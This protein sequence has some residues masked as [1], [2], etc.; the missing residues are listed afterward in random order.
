MW[1]NGFEGWYYKHQKGGKM[2]AFIPGRAK[3]DAFVQMLT[4]A[5]SRMF[6]VENFA[7]RGDTVEAGGCTF[8]P[9][10]CSVALPGVYGELSYGPIT[11]L[12]SDIM[13]PFRFLPM[14]CRHGVVSMAHTIRGSITADGVRQDFDGG[15][16][17]IEK[18]SGTSFPSA[19][20]W[21][22]CGDFS[23]PCSLM[24]SLA[25]IPFCGI[26]FRGC[27]CAVVYRG[28]EYRF[29]T[30]NGVK[31]LEASPHRVCLARG[32]L[33]LDVGI[34]PSNGGHPLLSP[35]KGNMSGVIRESGN[36]AVRARLFDRGEPVFDL[37]SCR[38]VYE[39]FP[40]RREEILNNS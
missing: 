6:E 14:E 35:E 27:I 36:A 37:K 17:Y 28:R 1:N 10:G 24:L 31:I 23:Q 21:L 16:G 9:L 2:V 29:A 12:K 18:D 26:S 39:Y 3:G 13:G 19:Y 33:L 25:R 22:Q 40:G 38:A 11:P 20:L 4:P 34:Q 30:Y 8:S 15:T 7:V 32:G 5:G